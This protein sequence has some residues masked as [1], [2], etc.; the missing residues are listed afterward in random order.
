MGFFVSTA[1]KLALSIAVTNTQ[2]DKNLNLHLHT[3]WG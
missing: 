2:F 1:E 3:K